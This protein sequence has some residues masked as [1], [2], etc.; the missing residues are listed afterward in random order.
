MPLNTDTFTVHDLADFPIVHARPE[1][2]VSG[3]AADW[4]REMNALIAEGTPFAVVFPTGP[5]EEDH[6][7]RKYR[8]IWLK[9]NKRALGRLCVS[10]IVVEPDGLKRVA[11]KA[12]TLTAVKA[13]QIRMD[14]VAS[15]DDA[16]PLAR[17]LLAPPA[18][19]APN[20]TGRLT[21]QAVEDEVD[22]PVQG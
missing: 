9:A 8:A 7:D 19:E 12:Q 22:R 5:F 15:L 20:S 1:A 3:Y 11:L 21:P 6:Q 13:F 14:V 18:T 4:A 10:L 17:S 2:I 16:V